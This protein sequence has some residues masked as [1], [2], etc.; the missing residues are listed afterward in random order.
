MRIDD[1]ETFRQRHAESTINLWQPR[2]DLFAVLRIEWRE[3]REAF[4]YRLELQLLIKPLELMDTL[5]E[6]FG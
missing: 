3:L 5:L 6:P 4:Q 2:A 1:L